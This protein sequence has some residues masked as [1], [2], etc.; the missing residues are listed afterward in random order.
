MI[1]D[2]LAH[3]SQYTALSPRFQA[4]FAFLKKFDGTA[5][6]GKYEIDGTNLYA[7]VQK[8]TTKPSAGRQ[9]EAHLKYIDIQYVHSG[10]ETILWAPLP[11]LKTPTIPYDEK[12][13]AAMY[14]L[15]PD[16]FDINLSAGMFTILFPGDGHVPTCT[17]GAPSEVSKVVVKVKI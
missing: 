12:G 9:F 13:E 2:I 10:R 14:A 16:S 11:A 4:A 8:Y 15:I 6:P 3:S 5:A 17:W 7:L 1:L